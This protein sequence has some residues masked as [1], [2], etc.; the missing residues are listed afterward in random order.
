MA[1]PRRIRT[2]REELE[3]LREQ[4]N[5]MRATMRT[6]REIDSTMGGLPKAFGEN[7]PSGAVKDKP[8][9]YDGSFHSE[10]Y[11]TY[12]Q[13]HDQMG[14]AIGSGMNPRGRVHDVISPAIAR[15]QETGA[16]IAPYTDL[17]PIGSEAEYE[18]KYMKAPGGAAYAA[19]LKFNRVQA[20]RLQAETFGTEVAMMRRESSKLVSQAIT[21]MA[22]RLAAAGKV[23]PS[24]MQDF[25]TS[26][27]RRLQTE[28]PWIDQNAPDKNNARRTGLGNLGLTPSDLRRIGGEVYDVKPRSQFN[29]AVNPSG[30]A[31]PTLRPL[32]KSP[33]EPRTQSGSQGI[34]DIFK[35]S[36]GGGGTLASVAFAGP[37]LI[38]GGE[39]PGGDISD[40][41]NT[42]SVMGASRPT[43][44]ARTVLS[45]MRNP[46]LSPEQRYTIWQRF[47]PKRFR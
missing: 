37:A 18:K 39:T 40:W 4:R 25:T 3:W 2:G 41:K 31:K 45:S 5:R 12:K 7:T 9:D 21:G 16:R 8:Q 44:T 1:A 20:P 15:N 29:T 10:Y 46:A 6:L 24:Q 34:P 22:H 26:F 38:G 32:S 33:L 27:V 19:G 13:L 14:A 11:K 30:P 23:K 35:K 47:G 28:A 42:Q 17:K 36:W 43:F